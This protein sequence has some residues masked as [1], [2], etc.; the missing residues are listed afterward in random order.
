MC[1]IPQIKIGIK[2]LDFTSHRG[3]MAALLTD[4]REVIV[5][6]SLFPDIRKLSVKERGSWMVLDDQF[7]TFA[8]LSKVFSITDLMKL[9]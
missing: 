4:G 3:K 9:A 2:K 5:P 7:F 6:L 1:K 8:H